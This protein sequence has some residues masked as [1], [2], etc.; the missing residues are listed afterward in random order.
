VYGKCQRYLLQVLFPFVLR[1]EALSCPVPWREEG[2]TPCCGTELARENL[3]TRKFNHF[4]L[5]N[6]ENLLIV[7]NNYY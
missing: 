5:K 4:F 3:S 1:M 2:S 6:M 7:K